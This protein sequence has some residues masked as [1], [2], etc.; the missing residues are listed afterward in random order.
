M[1]ISLSYLYA[2][3]GDK[4]RT[5]IR[6]TTYKSTNSNN[7]CELITDKMATVLVLPLYNKLEQSQT[8]ETKSKAWFHSHIDL[9]LAQTFAYIHLFART[10]TPCSPWPMS[11][12]FES[13]PSIPSDP[14]KLGRQFAERTVRLLR[15]KR[16]T[17]M[18]FERWSLRANF[19]S[20][21]G[22]W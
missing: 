10:L 8:A 2:E 9:M 17:L 4:S 5:N 22:H 11:M 19:F 20:H 15:G 7:N 14:S 16:W 6:S 18:C 12:F 1:K 13:D 21:T 3:A